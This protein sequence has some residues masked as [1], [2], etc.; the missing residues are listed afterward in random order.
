MHD[1]DEEDRNIGL[2]KFVLDL[3]KKDSFMS[4]S[5]KNFFRSSSPIDKKILMC[6]FDDCSKFYSNVLNFIL[7]HN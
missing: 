6:P 1:S 5:G 7:Y 4:P 2:K 3:E